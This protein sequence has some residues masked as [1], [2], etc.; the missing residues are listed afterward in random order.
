MEWIESTSSTPSTEFPLDLRAN[1]PRPPWRYS[2]RYIRETLPG[3][4]EH[5]FN[6]ALMSPDSILLSSS[7]A[8]AENALL[9]QFSSIIVHSAFHLPKSHSK[10]WIRDGRHIA[11]LDANL[12]RAI[13]LF[14]EIDADAS[15]LDSDGAGNW[16][17]ETYFSF[18]GCYRIL[19]WSMQDFIRNKEGHDHIFSPE[20]KVRLSRYSTI[21]ER[22]EEE[23]T[24]EL[25]SQ[26]RKRAPGD[27]DGDDLVVRWNDIIIPRWEWARVEIE[28]VADHPILSGDPNRGYVTRYAFSIL[29]KH[30]LAAA[31]AE[32]CVLGGL[33]QLCLRLT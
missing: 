8:C 2:S 22:Q 33:R 13:P 28:K 1:A 12:G 10:L 5:I 4:T 19:R 20:Q 23:A 25:L 24:S 21:A 3:E 32:R 7:Q 15:V 30:I 11:C 26:K 14:R 27:V 6:R 18:D 16:F 31:A 17:I 29:N 9:N